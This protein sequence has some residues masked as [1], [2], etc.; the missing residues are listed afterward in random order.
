MKMYKS[1][2][3]LIQNQLLLPLQKLHYAEVKAVKGWKP[4]KEKPTLKR[5]DKAVMDP[6]VYYGWLYQNLTHTSCFTVLAIAGVFA[7]IL[8]PLWPNFMK[9]G[10]WY[11]SMGA[12]G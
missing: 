1:F 10:V 3:L 7:V 12:L 6:D 11:L 5:A 2:V 8:F 4:N 9:R